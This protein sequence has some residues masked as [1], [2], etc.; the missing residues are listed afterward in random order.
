MLL[1]ALIEYYSGRYNVYKARPQ[2]ILKSCKDSDYYTFTFFFIT[3]PISMKH[4][5]IFNGLL[6]TTGLVSTHSWNLFSLFFDPVFFHSL[7]MKLY[8]MYLMR[9]F[10]ISCFVYGLFLF[11]RLYSKRYS[12]REIKWSVSLKKIYR[13]V[14]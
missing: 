10:C 3:Q 5:S 2:E 4:V 11:S 12:W 9:H 8:F 7:T 1:D 14:T 13:I 6:K